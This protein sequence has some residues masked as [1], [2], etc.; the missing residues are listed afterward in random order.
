[1]DDTFHWRNPVR[2]RPDSAGTIQNRQSGSM[3][4]S[5]IMTAESSKIDIKDLS[6]QQ[7]ADWLTHR[8][9]RAFRADQILRWVYLRQTDHFNSM[10]NLGKALRADL[11]A[12]FANPRLQVENETRSQDGSRKLLFRRTTITSRRS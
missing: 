2:K 8:G 9:S 5:H 12:A 4:G 11:S 1:M 3:G 7:L 6:R 10:T